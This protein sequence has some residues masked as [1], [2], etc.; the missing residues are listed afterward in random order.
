M[1][2]YEYFLTKINTRIS[3]VLKNDI[4]ISATLLHVDPFINLTIGDI[5]TDEI[6]LQNMDLCSVRGFSIRTVE[7]E[8]DDSI[9]RLNDGSRLCLTDI[10]KLNI[11]IRNEEIKE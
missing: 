8:K 1:L 5:E 11:F 7:I 4:K 6:S 10:S 2:F 9:D 3:L